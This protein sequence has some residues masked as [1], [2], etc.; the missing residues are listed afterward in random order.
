[1]GILSGKLSQDD[2]DTVSSIQNHSE[3]EDGFSN[4][5]G[6]EDNILG[7]F[8]DLDSLFGESSGSGFDNGDTFGNSGNNGFPS[9]NNGFPSTNNGFPNTNNGFG[10][11]SF[12]NTNNGFGNTNNGFGDN[13]FGNTNNGFPNAN[14][15]F[16]NANNIFGIGQ[17]QQ[18]PQQDAMDK[19]IDGSM[20]AAE[21]IGE[22]LLEMCKSFKERNID[23]IGYFNTNLMKLGVAS[24]GLG[25]FAIIIGFVTSYSIIKSVAT[26]LILAGGLTGATGLG[27]IGVAALILTRRGETGGI[28]IDDIAD[29]PYDDNDNVT[30][31]VE[32]DSGSLAD[33]LFGDDFDDLFD[34]EDEEE[35]EPEIQSEPEV[36]E[37]EKEIVTPVKIDY[38]QSLEDVHENTYIDRKTLVDTFTRMLPTN[39]LGFSDKTE[40]DRDS[41]DFLELKTMCLKALSNI[42][43]CSLSEV[44]SDVEKIT[45]TIFSYEILLKRVNKVRNVDDIANEIMYYFDDDDDDTSSK[46]TCSAKISGDFYKITITKGSNPVV[47]FGDIFKNE[48]NKEY[49]Y[50]TSH[51]LPIITG[52]N[53]VGK[54]ILNDAKIFDT[55]L[56]AGKPRSGKSW[57]ILSLLMALMLFNTPE[58][59]QFILVDPKETKLFDT[60]AL[61]PHVCGLHNDKKILDILD[62]IIEVEAKRRKKLLLDNNCDDIWALRKKG[63]KLPILYLVIDEYLSVM[64]HLDKEDQKKFDNKI[65]ILISQL[66]SQGV[67]LIFVPHRATGVVNKTN[68]TMLQFTAAVKA[69]IADI[70]DTLGIKKWTRSLT[71]EGDIALK[72]SALTNAIFVKGSALTP[73]DDQNTEFMLNAAK[74]FYKMGVSVPPNS[75]MKVAYNRDENKI[76]E[77]LMGEQHIVQFNADNVKA[78]LDNDNDDIENGYNEDNRDRFDFSNI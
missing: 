32:A 54:V 2:I 73:D 9:T 1:M 17:Q 7:G 62:D 15:G 47:T 35:Q 3:F 36:K 39:T 67:R 29:E 41:A 37:E 38:R 23:D 52:I 10:D 34:D 68:R 49:F 46:K 75:G 22:I 13:S 60:M 24:M 28:T 27:G 76:R 16:P 77:K 71:H 65:Q 21:N 51:K 74:V 12:G 56:I 6:E 8:D 57:Y 25:I 78:E 31:T 58:D 5:N 40:M 4:T 64:N 70:E 19:V 72:T 50:D 33:E 43:N 44:D 45:E 30:E 66:P 69:D 11:N 55:M 48:K 14:N 42:M 20:V 53:D 18:A 26:E 63:I 61:M 59:V